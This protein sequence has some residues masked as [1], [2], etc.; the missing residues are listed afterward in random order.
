MA[1]NNFPDGVAPDTP[2]MLPN[3]PAPESLLPQL[4]H[5]DESWIATNAT[6]APGIQPKTATNPEGELI[7]IPFS[8][9][10]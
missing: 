10:P 5:D 4:T 1:T 2:G 9:H 3:T 7:G 6:R 8:A